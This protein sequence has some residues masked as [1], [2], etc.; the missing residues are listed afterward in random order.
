MGLRGVTV[1]C[2]NVLL[3]LGACSGS[4]AGAQAPSPIA[5][6]TAITNSAPT[7]SATASA[8]EAEA[9]TSPPVTGGAVPTTDAT[10]LPAAARARTAAGAEAFSRHYFDALNTAWTTT[11]ADIL[12]ALSAASCKTCTLYIKT[13]DDLRQKG[14]HYAGPSGFVGAAIPLPGAT[15]SIQYIEIAYRQNSATIIDATG[16]VTEKVPVLGSFIVA[17]TQWSSS[18]W[19]MAKIQVVPK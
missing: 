16:R 14:L 2:A 12:R 6:P 9:T 18:G 4:G 15:P 17:T 7:T 13:A 10:S 3:L 8:P 19:R 1:L 5:T 11:D